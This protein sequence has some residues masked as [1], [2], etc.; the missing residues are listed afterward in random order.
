MSDFQ[1]TAYTTPTIA[2][3]VETDQSLRL[4]FG[5][6]VEFV[7]Q[8]DGEPSEPLFPK[9]ATSLESFLQ[10]AYGTMD[11]WVRWV[12]GEGRSPDTFDGDQ[13]LD[14]RLEIYSTSASFTPQNNELDVVGPIEELATDNYKPRNWIGANNQT[15]AFN[16]VIDTKWLAMPYS[17]WGVW[18]PGVIAFDDRR[19]TER[20]LGASTN[21]Y[22][23]RKVVTRWGDHV[24]RE[25][26]LEF[27]PVTQ[28]FAH[29]RVNPI[30]ESA[31]VRRSNPNN[32]FENFSEATTQDRVYWIYDRIPKPDEFNFA[33]D[34]LEGFRYR[35]AR[36]LDSWTSDDRAHSER[37]NTRY[38]DVTIE[39]SEWDDLDQDGGGY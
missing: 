29:R 15:M 6:G 18:N 35:K 10:A 37:G 19:H 7:W 14:P 24:V 38:Y 33:V 9:L 25:L 8:E 11:I 12:Y 27:T 3:T 17:P 16:S 23:G 21:S 13:K 28:M 31:P 39:F 30:W 34:Y 1:S 26:G 2:W 4:N 20:A 5:N 36:H 32:L 22:S